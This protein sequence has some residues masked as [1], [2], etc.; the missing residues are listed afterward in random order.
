MVMRVYR[1]TD[2]SAPVLTGQV[3]TLVALLDAVLVNGYGSMT[4]AGWT[5][6][7]TG[8][9]KAVFRNSSSTGTGHYLR[10]QDDVATHGRAYVLGY[11]AMTTVD[12]GTNPFPSTVATYHGWGKSNTNDATARPWVIFADDQRFYIFVQSGES[13][14]DWVTGFFG[15]I[16]SYKAVDPYRSCLVARHSTSGASNQVF[17][18]DYLGYMHNNSSGYAGSAVFGG[19]PRNHAG[20]YGPTLVVRTTD[21][22]KATMGTSSPNAA[23]YA[24]APSGGLAYPDPAG[25]SLW[26]APT[27]VLNSAGGNVIRGHMPGLWAP[28]HARPLSNNDT[29]SGTGAMTGKTFEAFN[30]Y[31]SG[32]LMM[33]TSDT[34]S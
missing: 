16:V 8:T 14:S 28:M 22:V 17:G 19:M 15:D 25:A 33:E 9:N 32:Q 3:G 18:L 12:A 27:W 29:F 23:F 31:S 30:I 13:S 11:E 2:T 10:V 34:W 21:T 1:S 6:P 7:Y 4:A 26:L 20:T 5:K 24:G